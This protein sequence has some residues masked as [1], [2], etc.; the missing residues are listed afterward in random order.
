MPLRWG[1]ADSEKV[2]KD[3]GAG[4]SL[5]DDESIEF[6]GKTRRDL[7]IFTDRRLIVTDTQGLMNKKTTYSSIPYRSLARWSVETK[8]RGWDGSSGS[9]RRSNHWSHSNS[10][11]RRVLRRS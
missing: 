8:G 3:H 5:A 1:R 6:A 9:G 2:I 7:L 4:L 11:P 10:R